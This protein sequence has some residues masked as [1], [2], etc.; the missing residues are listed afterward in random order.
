[1]PNQRLPDCR[2][3][4]RDDS[5]TSASSHPELLIGEIVMR[6]RIQIPLTPRDGEVISTWSRR[7]LAAC[8]IGAAVIVGYSMT[9]PAATTIATHESK[10][11]QTLAGSCMQW[12]EAAGNAIARLAHSTKDADLRRLN[13][14]VV[15]VR[16]ARRNCEEGWLR[17]ACQDYYAV[18]SNVSAQTHAAMP[19]CLPAADG[20]T[21]AP[22][23]QPQ[24]N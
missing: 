20:A 22:T 4:R 19:A 7:M 3:P 17:L 18:A 23:R 12:H 21:G 13:D 14:A 2:P 11:G 15:R 8:A 6:P 10:G 24:R 16:R 9:K 5:I 1:M